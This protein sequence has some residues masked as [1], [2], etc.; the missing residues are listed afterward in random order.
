MLT[1]LLTTKTKKNNWSMDRWLKIFNFH[2]WI[3]N[4]NLSSKRLPYEWRN[5]YIWMTHLFHREYMWLQSQ[6][7][8]GDLQVKSVRVSR[9]CLRSLFREAVIHKSVCLKEKS[10][11]CFQSIWKATVSVSWQLGTQNIC[12]FLE[13]VHHAVC[14]LER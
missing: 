13:Q 9:I 5:L 1:K 10:G 3:L 8:K 7:L 2:L 12:Y 4:I 14:D 11:T 6:L